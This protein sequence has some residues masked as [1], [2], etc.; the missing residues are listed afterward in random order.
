M[1]IFIAEKSLDGLLSA[2]FYSFTQKTAPGKVT[3]G[4]AFQPGMYDSVIKIETNAPQAERVKKGLIRY[5]GADIVRRLSVCLLSCEEEAF[6]AAFR[7]AYKT[8]FLRKDISGNMA[9]PVTAQFIFTEQ[10]V[11]RER[12]NILGFLRFAE[13]AGGVIYARYSPDN[14]ITELVAPHFLKRLSGLAFVIHDVKRNKAAV[15]DGYSLKMMRT[16]EAAFIPSAEEKNFAALWKRYY[17]E[18]NIPE[19]LNPRQQRRCM[20]VR[21]R[22]FMPETYEKF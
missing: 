14:D 20:P 10:K 7:Y 9:D 13:S 2:L 19:R 3:D 15:S 17:E 18:I 5:G 11:W 16:G 4:T 12:H 22:K 8:L 21:Y 6:T 1:I